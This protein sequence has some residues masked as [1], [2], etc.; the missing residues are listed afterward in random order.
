MSVDQLIAEIKLLPQEQRMQVVDAILN[1]D[2]SWIPESF[3]QG[4]KDFE[5][6]RTV[7]MEVAIHEKPP[8]QE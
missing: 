5:E 4:M 8:G 3:K 7:S 2:D 1:E 6:G